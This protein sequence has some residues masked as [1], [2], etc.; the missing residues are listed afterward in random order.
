MLNP[1][2]VNNMTNR[3]TF[4]LG[5]MSPFLS[6]SNS[7]HERRSREVQ[8]PE[9]RKVYSCRALCGGN[10]TALLGRVANIAHT[11]FNRATQRNRRYVNLAT[12]SPGKEAINFSGPT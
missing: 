4:P 6:G 10:F 12:S 9:S 1:M 2:P 3:A 11:D 8:H 5:V 7:P